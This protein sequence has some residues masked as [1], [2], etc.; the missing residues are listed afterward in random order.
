MKEWKLGSTLFTSICQK[1]E[2]FD[3]MQNCKIIQQNMQLSNTI[4]PPRYFS[5]C[6]SPNTIML[7]FYLA[8]RPHFLLV[9]FCLFSWRQENHTFPAPPQ[10]Y[11]K[12]SVFIKRKGKINKNI[13]K[14]I[15][16]LQTK[17]TLNCQE[18]PTMTVE[19]QHR[20]DQQSQQDIQR[21]LAS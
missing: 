11:Y 20:T 2:N 14:I 10:Q 3:M 15:F 12:V 19:R 17:L 4:F 13:K 6:N 5:Y 7:H 9:G 18:Q 1:F 16:Y 8:E 21:I